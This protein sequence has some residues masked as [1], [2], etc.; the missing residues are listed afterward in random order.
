MFTR[1]CIVYGVAVE[2]FGLG[3]LFAFEYLLQPGLRYLLLL[4]LP[5]YNINIGHSGAYAA[6]AGRSASR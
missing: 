6:S 3:D 1:K 2:A 5:L 4:A